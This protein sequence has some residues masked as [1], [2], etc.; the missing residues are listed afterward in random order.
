MRVAEALHHGA[1]AVEV[2]VGPLG[3][4]GVGR[5]R[6]R[7]A[8]LAPVEPLEQ[9]LPDNDVVIMPHGF[10]TDMPHLD[11]YRDTWVVLASRDH[12]DID[13]AVTLWHI[14]FRVAPSQRV[15]VFDHLKL[16][17]RMLMM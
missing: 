9:T 3:D 2:G 10:L 7:F 15:A 14:L 13:D 5:A 6:L 12:P 4:F 8:G 11:L 17:L 16:L 1:G